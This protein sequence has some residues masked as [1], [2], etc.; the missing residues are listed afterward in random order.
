MSIDD[1]TAVGELQRVEA[2]PG[3]V[4]VL[5]VPK[6]MSREQAATFM[7]LAWRP[8]MG[9]APLLFVDGGARLGVVSQAPTTSGPLM[10]QPV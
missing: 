5:H 4:F 9:D 6:P 7:E 3:D 1:I 2:R 8:I 10:H